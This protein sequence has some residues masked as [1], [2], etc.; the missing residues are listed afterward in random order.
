MLV[1]PDS[2]EARAPRTDGNADGLAPFDPAHRGEWWWRQ[3][4]WSKRE[5]RLEQDGRLVAVL[6]RERL[7]ST[8]SRMRFSDAAFEMHRN[9]LGNADLRQFG[10]KEPLARFVSRWLGGGRVEPADGEPLELVRSG[11]LWN[12]AHELRTTDGLLLVRFESHDHFL[13]R[14]VQIVP[15]DSARRR[16]DLLPLLALTAAVIFAPKRHSY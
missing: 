9:W 1:V 12:R 11:I 15:E 3:P 10:A 8:T 4:K 14:D 7:F 6:E 16:Q 5:W 2:R 13:T